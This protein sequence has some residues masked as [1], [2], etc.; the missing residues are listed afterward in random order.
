MITGSLF[1]DYSCARIIVC[2]NYFVFHASSY[3]L[4][5]ILTFSGLISNN[6]IIILISDAA[7][8]ESL[9]VEKSRLQIV[10]YSFNVT[11]YQFVANIELPLALYPI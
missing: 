10:V 2:F 8:V 11:F 1:A 3:S 4:I 6:L 9:N 5:I 7:R